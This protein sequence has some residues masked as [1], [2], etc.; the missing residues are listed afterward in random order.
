M[1]SG[2]IPRSERGVMQG[3]ELWS[4]LPQ[5]LSNYPISRTIATGDCAWNML[6]GKMRSKR[7]HNLLVVEFVTR[8]SRELRLAP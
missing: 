5:E 7:V 8:E 2:L 1:R 4:R 3:M 6:V